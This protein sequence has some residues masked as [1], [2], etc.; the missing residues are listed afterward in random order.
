MRHFEPRS[1]PVSPVHINNVCMKS[2]QAQLTEPAAM[3]RSE[4]GGEA[5][6]KVASKQKCKQSGR[7]QMIFPYSNKMEN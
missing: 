2:Y 7:V 6:H 4:R 1:L 3:K 5:Q